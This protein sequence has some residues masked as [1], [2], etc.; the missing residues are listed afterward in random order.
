VD[1]F[2]VIND[3]L[4]RYSA[5]LAERPQIVVANKADLPDS[6]GRRR[7]VEELCAREGRPLFVISAATGQGLRELVH[8][9]AARLEGSGWLRAAS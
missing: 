1:D 9:T 7:R 4:R 8:A 2:A 5:E 6:A 3:E